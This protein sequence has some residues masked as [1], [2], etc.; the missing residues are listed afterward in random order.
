MNHHWLKVNFRAPEGTLRWSNVQWAWP[1]YEGSAEIPRATNLSDY[2][3]ELLRVTPKRVQANYVMWR[4]AGASISYLTEDLR[5]RQ[6][7]YVTALSG[8][9]ERESR[10]KECSDTTS[11]R[12]KQIRLQTVDTRGKSP[13]MP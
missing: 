8:K 13:R 9:T 11:S 3:Q 7:S 10:W 4:V 5:R 2:P 6:L 1:K 12:Y